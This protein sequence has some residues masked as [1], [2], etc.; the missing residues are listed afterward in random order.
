MMLRSLKSF[1]VQNLLKSTASLA[2][3][4]ISRYLSYQEAISQEFLRSRWELDDQE[5]LNL[6]ESR[7]QTFLYM[8]EI[9]RENELP[10]AL[11]LNEKT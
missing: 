8:I 3:N 6:H 10:G 1:N 9:V 2:G 11:A 4:S 5:K 7:K